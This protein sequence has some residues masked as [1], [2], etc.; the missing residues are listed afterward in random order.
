MKKNAS[1]LAAVLALLLTLTAALPAAGASFPVEDGERLLTILFT[2]D[3]HD[4]FYP[5]AADVGGYTRLATLLERERANS[6]GAVV[7]VD[8]GDFSMGSPFQTIYATDAPELRALGA[9]DYDVVT[10]GNHEYDYRPQGLADMLSAAQTAQKAWHDVLVSDLSDQDAVKKCLEEYGVPGNLPAIV[11][12]NYKTPKDPSDPASQAL[13]KAMADYPVTDYT[14]LER[15]VRWPSGHEVTVKIAVFGIMGVDSDECAPMS[16]MELED[17]IAA[18]QRVVKEIQE[19]EQPDFVICLSHSGTEKGRGED[20]KLAKKVDGI[21]VIISGHTHS[22]LE[23]PIEVNDTL[24]VSCGP[25]TQNLGKLVLSKGREESK[26]KLK[27]YALLPI[28]ASV[29]E[30]EDMIKLA[31][32]FKTKVDENYL[33]Q[34]HM[35]YD[36]VLATAQQDFTRAETGDFIGESYIA[37]IQEV[38][39]EDYVPIAFA[40]APDGVIRGS[41][42]QGNITASQAFDILSLGVGSDGTPGYPLVSVY[43]TGKDLKNTFEVDASISDLMNAATLYG[44]GCCWEYNPRRMFLR[45]VVESGL[46]SNVQAEKTEGGYSIGYHADEID[47]KALYRVVA[48]LYSGQML[49]AVKGKSFG[50]LSITP[51]DENGNEITDFEDYIIHDEDGNEV[52]AWYAFAHHLEEKGE[53]DSGLVVKSKYKLAGTFADELWP[54]GVLFVILLPIVAVVVFVRKLLRRRKRGNGFTPPYRGR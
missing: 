53:V 22:T 36:G 35:S 10:F 45:R 7:T 5:D 2:H 28:D 9:M 49:S 24:I 13:V 21:D 12:A 44:A 15:P 41:I 1:R 46:A 34:Y 8:G 18:A 19:K 20:Y 27:Y 32:L 39:G 50:L 52:K 4:H 26:A 48:D 29:E 3:T 31:E 42:K 33:S 25:Y 43:L 11:Q 54:I 16:G 51:R 37:T 47:D 40:V 6:S 14:I 23:E 38:E 30:D 17:P